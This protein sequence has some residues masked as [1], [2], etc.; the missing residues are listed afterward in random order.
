MLAISSIL[1]FTLFSCD[2]ITSELNNQTPP[3]DEKVPVTQIADTLEGQQ[4]QSVEFHVSDYFK[5]E[6]TIVSATFYGD[7]LEVTD[8]L[9]GTFRVSHTQNQDGLFTL[10][11]EISNS[12]DYTLETELTYHILPDD[13]TPPPPPSSDETLVIMPLGDSM[14]NDSRPRV[15]LWNLLEKDGHSL[16][17][18]G[19]QYQRSSIP[20]PDHEG[21]GGITVQGIIDKAQSLMQTHHPAYI[22]LM[23]G[24]N[25]IAW[26][27]DESGS[28]IADRWNRLIDILFESSEA[29]TYIIAA[30]IPPVSSKNVGSS[31]MPNRDRAQLVED[32]NQALRTHIENRRANGDL[33]ILA[34]MEAALDAG[35]HLSGDGVHL[36]DEGYA[37]M[38]TVYYEAINKALR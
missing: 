28:E 37:I 27:F 10:N 15:K 34:D 23:A 29:G 9:N 32:Y 3:E 30:T 8:L 36:N 38:G 11:A 25:D 17:Y 22:A 7:Q 18:V 26:Y 4:G 16:D 20:D 35:Q 2:Q 5:S 14:T 19:N 12:T 1:I 21:V 6:A 24:T 33:I 31:D 13:D